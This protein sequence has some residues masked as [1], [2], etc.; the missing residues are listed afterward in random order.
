MFINV[1]AIGK[2]VYN[3][4]ETLE[5]SK[6]TKNNNDS[7]YIFKQSMKNKQQQFDI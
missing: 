7:K 1:C 3:K 4:Y 5:E 6:Q 2:R